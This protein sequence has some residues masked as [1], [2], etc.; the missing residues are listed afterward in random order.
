MNEDKI[1]VTGVVTLDKVTPVIKALFGCFGISD[2]VDKDSFAYIS[3][4]DGYTTAKWSHVFDALFLLAE[5]LKVTLPKNSKSNH[6]DCIR[7]LAQYYD[8]ENAPNIEAMKDYVFDMDDMPNIEVLFVIACF[9]RDGHGIGS[10]SHFGTWTDEENLPGSYSG[11]AAE[12]I[13]M[14]QNMTDPVCRRAL[15]AFALSEGHN[16]KAVELMLEDFQSRLSE[17]IDEDDRA[18][19]R[20]IF[21]DQLTTHTHPKTNEA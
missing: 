7:A 2:T 19:V 21:I 5:K 3:P 1:I 10:I 11:F 14:Y 18:L 4:S 15:L 20:R 13:V 8:A 16:E 17:I 6:F 9:L 12:K